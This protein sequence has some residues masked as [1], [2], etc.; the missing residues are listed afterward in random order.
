VSHRHGAA[1]TGHSGGD[2]SW[3]AGAGI[4][5]GAAAGVIPAVA[6]TEGSI[7]YVSAS[8]AIAANL[9]VA[10]IRNAAGR[11]VLP[12]LRNIENAAQSVTAAQPGGALDIVNPPRSQSIAYPISMFSYALVPANPPQAASVKTFITYAIGPGQASGA[13]LDFAPLPAAVQSADRQALDSLVH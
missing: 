11:F 4:N 10:A 1:R 8:D 7:G 6:H 12:D 2:L 9:T 13:A 5:A 3:P